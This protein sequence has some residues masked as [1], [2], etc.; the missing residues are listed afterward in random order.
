MGE[1]DILNAIVDRRIV[2]A[3]WEDAGES[4]LILT[5][6]DGLKVKIDSV[7]DALHLESFVTIHQVK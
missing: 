7:V 2:K 3:E 1:N 6:H 5:L 4:V